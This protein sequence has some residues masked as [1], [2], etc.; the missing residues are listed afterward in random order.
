MLRNGMSDV[1]AGPKIKCFTTSAVTGVRTRTRAL[2]LSK[3]GIHSLRTHQILYQQFYDL[4]YRRREAES[5]QPLQ[6]VPPVTSG[7]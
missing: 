6:G 4:E 2:K 3:T 7:R 5:T 1:V